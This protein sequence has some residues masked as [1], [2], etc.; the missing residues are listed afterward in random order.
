M[1]IKSVNR[2]ALLS[3]KSLETWCLLSVLWHFHV[4]FT[5]EHSSHTMTIWMISM[6]G[7]LPIEQPLAAYR[8][9]SFTVFIL[10]FTLC[11]L[12]QSFPNS[13]SKDYPSGASFNVRTAPTSPSVEWSLLVNNSRLSMICVLVTRTGWNTAISLVSPLSNSS[14][15]L[16]CLYL[17]SR[18][19]L[20]LFDT[21]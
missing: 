8:Q 13:R 20:R 19:L 4:S 14:L 16:Y 21:S 2:L 15:S 1:S 7:W 9:L 3:A 5:E 6:S 12:L 11:K 17:Y 18:N 10:N